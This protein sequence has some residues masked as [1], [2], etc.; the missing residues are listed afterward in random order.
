MPEPWAAIVAVAGVLV[1]LGGI[2]A[3]IRWL[4]VQLRKIVHLADDLLGEPARP[5][6]AARPG[7]MDRV[8]TLEDR[9]AE[10]KPN[11]GGSIKDQVTRMD[12]R[13]EQLE[14]RLVA[15][16]RTVVPDQPH[17]TPKAKRKKRGR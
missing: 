17:P 2:G 9:T 7:L 15:V 1:A 4:V 16:E 6:H 12:R 8:K 10:L 11:G 13:S 14:Q 5:G 3:A